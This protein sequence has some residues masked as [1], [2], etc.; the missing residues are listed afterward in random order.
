MQTMI[1]LQGPDSVNRGRA[2]HEPPKSVGDPIPE[3]SFDLESRVGKLC[4]N[5]L[6][7]F[8]LVFYQY[9]DIHRKT[10]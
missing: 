2:D 9:L 5:A 7:R 3:R 6:T 8:D 1:S 10:P 4:K